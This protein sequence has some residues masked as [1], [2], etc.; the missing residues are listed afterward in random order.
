MKKPKFI[1]LRTK[2]FIVLSGLMA[3]ILALQFYLAYQA[4]QHLLDELNRLSSRMNLAIDAHFAGVLEEIQEQEK[5]RWKKDTIGVP[6][7]AKTVSVHLS[8]DSLYADVLS[9]LQTVNIPSDSLKKLN[10]RIERKQLNEVFEKQYEIERFLRYSKIFQEDSLYHRDIKRVDSLTHKQ[11]LMN[12]KITSLLAK[13]DSL[14][15]ISKNDFIPSIEMIDVNLNNLKE[16]EKIHVKVV[17]NT[18]MKTTEMDESEGVIFRIP[19]FSLP[20]QPKLIRYNYQTAEI[21]KAV[22]A[23][24]QRNILITV[25][26]FGLS[27]LLILFI[28]HR[29]LKPIG[30]L[31]NSFK[32]VVNGDLD[33]RV[34]STSKD[35]IADLT[36]SFNHMVEELRKNA[37]KE[38]LLQRKERLAS[39]GQLAAGVAHEIKNPLNAINLTIEHLSDKFARKDKT[40]RKY[41]STIQNEI[42]RLDGIVDN[43]LNFIRSESLNRK[44]VDV[45]ALI[46]EVIHLL[47]SEINSRHIT[48]QFKDSPDF[49]L[50]LDAERFK[51]VLLNLIL[52]AIQAMPDGGD[53]TIETSAADKSII[54]SDTGEGIPVENLDKIFDLFYTTKSKGTGLGLPTAFKIVREHGGDIEIESDKGKGTSVLIKLSQNNV[55]DSGNAV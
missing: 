1:S 15:V 39:M 7:P 21:Q 9:E 29:F 19:D 38:K 32:Q 40:A 37:K 34:P 22:N 51:T 54:I 20:N 2:L 36:I 23:S 10:E 17:P 3:L 4:Q 25:A 41:V 33:V 11:Y 47:E 45:N 14:L 43:F 49:R 55:N 52:N 5:Y 24:L 50:S 30:T 44:E 48:F 16:E 46:A 18:Q 13:N 8:P 53:L 31:Q 12:Q 27:M 35:E 28:S 26:L 6:P 42:S